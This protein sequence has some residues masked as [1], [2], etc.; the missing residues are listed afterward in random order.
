MALDSRRSEPLAEKASTIENLLVL[1]RFR[2]AENASVELL[3]SSAYLPKSQTKQQR[4]AHVYVQAMYE[5]ERCVLLPTGPC[6]PQ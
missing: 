4:A 5:Q 2:D 6:Q 1:R 3:Q